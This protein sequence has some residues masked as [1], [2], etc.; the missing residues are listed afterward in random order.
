M[1]KFQGNHGTLF[2]DR[3]MICVT[4]FR[5]S[6]WFYRGMRACHRGSING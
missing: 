4:K 3:D 5:A 1:L 2:G 6:H